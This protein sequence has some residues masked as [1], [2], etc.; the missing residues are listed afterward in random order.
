MPQTCP[1]Y[2]LNRNIGEYN[3]PYILDGVLINT[4][5]HPEHLEV[6]ATS[7]VPPRP[8]IG[9]DNIYIPPELKKLGSKSMEM[10]CVSKK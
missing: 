7:L 5:E 1:C 9:T 10:C 3:L 2:T 8:Y 4:I 6:Q